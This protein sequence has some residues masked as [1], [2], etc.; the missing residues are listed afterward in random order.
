MG[1]SL[2]LPLPMGWRW[3]FHLTI[4]A[5]K[6]IPTSEEPHVRAGVYSVGWAGSAQLSTDKVG[7]EVGQV[8]QVRC[9][10]QFLS[11]RPLGQSLTP[12]QVGTQSPFTEQRN[13]PGQ[14]GGGEADGT[15][16]TCHHE[17]TGRCGI[18]VLHMYV[19]TC[20]HA[21]VHGGHP[22]P[23]TRTQHTHR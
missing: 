9:S 8:G 13:S 15:I 16:R 2:S 21:C 17:N 3:G 22:C 1:L 20:A 7:R 11:S 23:G 12:S 10:P 4:S 18:C 5:Q 19:S 6:E 14:A